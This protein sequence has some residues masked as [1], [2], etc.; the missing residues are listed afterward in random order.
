MTKEQVYDE[1]ISPLMQQIIA[2]CNEHKIANVMTFSLDHDTGLLCT[3]VN[4]EQETN[5]PELFQCIVD[6]LLPPQQSP[7]MVTVDHGDGTKT[8]TAILGG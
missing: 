3:T 1:Q 4:I 8:I 2:I 7:M 5:P 6:Q